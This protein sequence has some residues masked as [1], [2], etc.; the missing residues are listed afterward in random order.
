MVAH[1]DFRKVLVE[2][3]YRSPEHLRLDT[4]FC[5]IQRDMQ[6]GLQY[7]QEEHPLI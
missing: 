3:Q 4:Q 6:L 5:Y 7:I 1:D 2:T